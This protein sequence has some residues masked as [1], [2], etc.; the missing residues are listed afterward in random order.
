MTPIHYSDDRSESLEMNPELVVLNSPCFTG[1]QV[2]ITTSGASHTKLVK[3]MAQNFPPVMLFSS[4]FEQITTSHQQE[5]FFFFLNTLLQTNSLF[6][7]RNCETWSG[8]WAPCWGCTSRRP[9]ASS[10]SASRPTCCT[11]GASRLTP[12]T[13]PGTRP[14]GNSAILFFFLSFS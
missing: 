8:L 7:F 1:N 4:F 2:L 3:Y 12:W 5:A 9:R 11:P 10:C 14:R 6:G 13:A